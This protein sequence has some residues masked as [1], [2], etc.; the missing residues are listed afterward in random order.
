M[1][2]AVRS[3][4]V[5]NKMFKI[6]DVQWGEWVHSPWMLNTVYIKI[7]RLNYHQMVEMVDIHSS[8]FGWFIQLGAFGAYNV[9]H[10]NFSTPAPKT[11]L[12]NINPEPMSCSEVKEEVKKRSIHKQ[13]FCGSINVEKCHTALK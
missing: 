1:A 8:L 10:D 13:L 6:I 12:H 4:R 2:L 5:F 9:H 3:Q 11:E 7:G